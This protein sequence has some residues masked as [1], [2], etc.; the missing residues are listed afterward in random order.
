VGPVAEALGVLVGVKL[1]ELDL[2][3]LGEGVT[4]GVAETVTVLVSVMNGDM[5]RVAVGVGVSCADDTTTK[6]MKKKDQRVCIEEK[7]LSTV[8]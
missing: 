5:V 6:A 7:F 1:F 8:S 3:A 4:H 2:E